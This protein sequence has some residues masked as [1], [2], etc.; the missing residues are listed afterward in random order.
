LGAALAGLLTPA[1]LLPRFGLRVALLMVAALPLVALAIVAVA[2]RAFL[3]PRRIARLALVGGGLATA[4]ALLLLPIAG[5][6]T[7]RDPLH[8]Y[9]RVA[10]G[11][12]ARLLAYHEDAAANVAV[13]QRT[14]GNRVLAVNDQLALG[15]GGASR[16]EAMQGVLPALL[17]PGPKKA[18]ALGV[19]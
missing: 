15:G 16:V 17:H 1:V 5:G 19:G 10:G 8:F 6:S 4:A 13:V 12:G 3:A 14:D 11:P 9:R 18:L 2:D 7:L